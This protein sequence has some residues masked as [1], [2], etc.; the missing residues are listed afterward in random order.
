MTVP[1]S[2]FENRRRLAWWLAAVAFSL[3]IIV[4]LGQAVPVAHAG[5]QAAYLVICTALGIQQIP[6]PDAPAPSEERPSC[7]IC[8][9]H[10]LG[11]VM[12]AAA[13]LDFTPQSLTFETLV[14]AV[15]DQVAEGRAPRAPSNRDPPIV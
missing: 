13:T 12:L 7:P 14:H 8:Q 3:H 10:A 4:P 2:R 11:G 9:A 6:N 1:R 5:G 15:S